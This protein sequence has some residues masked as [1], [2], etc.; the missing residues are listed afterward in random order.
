MPKFD[1]LLYALVIFGWSTSWLPL[2]MQLGV[3]APE[4]SLV[5]RFMIA[6][7]LMAIITTMMGYPLKVKAREHLRFIALG[8]C[9]FSMNFN[10]FYYGGLYATSGLLA[11]VF[12]TAAL[13]N[14]L[15]VSI[16]TRTPPKKMMIVAAIMGFAGVG[17]LYSPQFEAGEGALTSLLLCLLGTLFFC[18]G[19]MISASSQKDGIPVMTANSWGM[20]Y[21]VSI[22]ALISLLRGHEFGI[23]MTAGY[24]GSLLW[25][26]VFSSVLAFSAY[27]VLIGHIGSGK[28]G[29]AT[30]V[31]PVGALLIST[32]FEDYQWSLAAVIGLAFVVG[33]NVVMLRSK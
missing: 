14:I 2:K 20:F 1:Y 22:L 12:S 28:A 24:I 25:L 13:V 15:L 8:F 29:Y 30:A 3:I 16:L 11:V 7:V 4:V 10:L 31:F 23:E 21:G 6:T 5:W 33:G 27:L 32:F 19:N 26:A 17:I 9:L 18:T